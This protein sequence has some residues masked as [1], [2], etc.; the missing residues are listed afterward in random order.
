M[1]TDGSE[2]SARFGKLRFS[3]MNRTQLLISSAL[4]FCLIGGALAGRVVGQQPTAQDDEVIRVE[5]DLTNLLFIATDKQN[6]FITSL[7]Q[8]D[9]RV[10]E[11]GVPQQLFTFQRET[12]RP[13]SIAFLIDVSGSEERTLSQEKGA[14]RT[15]IETIIRSKQD[16]AAI[17][18]FTD[19]A[20]LEQGLTNNV[21]GIGD[22]KQDGVNKGVL[23]TLADGTGGRAFFPKNETDLKAAF[24]QIEQ[25]LRLQYLIA[26]S[27]SNKKRDGT[28]RQMQIEITNPALLKDQLKLR[29]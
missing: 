13:L 12:A 11:D 17:I 21:L 23:N 15:F 2:N 7:R 1:G 18:P 16:Q 9:V 10:L 6:H 20:F 29:Y 3:R 27:S 25:E 26:Y 24:V 8:E 19:R 28:Y 14:A 4:I 22:S 5:S